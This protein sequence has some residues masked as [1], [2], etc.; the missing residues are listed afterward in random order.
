[1]DLLITETLYLRC[2]ILSLIFLTLFHTQLWQ[3]AGLFCCPFIHRWETSLL[4]NTPSGSFS[5]WLLP[6]AQQQL[7][8]KCPMYCEHQLKPSHPVLPL[9]SLV[10]FGI[11]QL[12]I[13]LLAI[14]SRLLSVLP[15]PAQ[16][17]PAYG[18]SCYSY[19]K[20]QTVFKCLLQH[21]YSPSWGQT[22]LSILPP[23]AYLFNPAF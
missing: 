9:S 8:D 7:T 16:S 4:W 14:F 2:F 13:Q 6:A 19:G 15:K 18:L 17:T 22:Q 5:N 20:T 1:M 21:P 10:N 23:I 12:H 3:Q 11:N